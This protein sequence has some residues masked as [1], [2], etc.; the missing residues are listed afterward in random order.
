[1]P[2]LLGA[3]YRFSARH[4]AGHA[5]ESDLANRSLAAARAAPEVYNYATREPGER[6]CK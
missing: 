4:S 1:M 2:F 5:I 3:R 6:L